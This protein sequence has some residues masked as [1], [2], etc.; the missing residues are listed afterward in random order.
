MCVRERERG[1][2]KGRGRGRGRGSGRGRGTEMDEEGVRETPSWD[3]R[4]YMIE[5]II[6]AQS[7]KEKRANHFPINRAR[8]QG[9]KD[10]NMQTPEEK[11]R[12]RGLVGAGI[13]AMPLFLRLPSQV[14]L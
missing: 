7:V 11:D 8:G 6:S 4:A 5:F 1:R 2:G 12:T 9:T 14:P 13:Q 3:M 10:T